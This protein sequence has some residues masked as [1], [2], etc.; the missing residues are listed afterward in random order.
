MKRKDESAG[1]RVWLYRKSG[2]RAICERLFKSFR[3]WGR[4]RMF[5]EDANISVMCFVILN[6]TIQ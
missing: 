3:W 1:G 2:A 6:T 4:Q 5:D